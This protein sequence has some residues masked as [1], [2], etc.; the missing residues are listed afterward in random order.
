MIH[1]DSISTSEHLI[2]L[3][4][5]ALGTLIECKNIREDLA[6]G[7]CHANQCKNI[8]ENCEEK[9]HFYHRESYPNLRMSKHY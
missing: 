6:G 4:R 3:S 7:S 5:K 1:Y 9:E 8:P 2:K